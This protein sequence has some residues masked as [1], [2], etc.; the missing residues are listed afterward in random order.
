M[1]A[2]YGFIALMASHIGAPESG[3]RL[4]PQPRLA[5]AIRISKRAKNRS[6]VCS[7]RALVIERVLS[8]FCSETWPPVWARCSATPHRTQPVNKHGE[9]RTL[10]SGFSEKG[11]ETAG[12]MKIDVEGAELIVLKGARQTLERLLRSSVRNEPRSATHGGHD[13]EDIY[14]LLEELG[15]QGFLMLPTMCCEP[16]DR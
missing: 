1:G 10:D 12:V 3:L 2:N 4:E 9:Y 6:L 11:L 16:N 8:N 13:Q 14:S 7:K 15:Y 5:Q